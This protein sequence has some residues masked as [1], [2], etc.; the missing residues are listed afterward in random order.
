MELVTV[1]RE[2]RGLDLPRVL[3]NCLED[4]EVL[5]VVEGIPIVASKLDG[6]SAILLEIQRIDWVLNNAIGLQV[7]DDV[8]ISDLGVA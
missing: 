2:F 1:D 6:G 3:I 7:E 4:V 8:L 5:V